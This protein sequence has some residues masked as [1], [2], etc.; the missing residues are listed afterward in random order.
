MYGVEEKVRAEKERGL[1]KCEPEKEERKTRRGKEGGDHLNDSD[2][3]VLRLYVP[4]GFQFP[5]E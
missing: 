2:D 4:T 5:F 3:F 1:R